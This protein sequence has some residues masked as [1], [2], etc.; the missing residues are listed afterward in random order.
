MTEEPHDTIEIDGTEYE[1]V[2]P[3]FEEKQFPCE[4]RID[5]EVVGFETREQL[6]E[7]VEG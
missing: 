3:M 7:Y 4:V 1:V 6:E 2:R 5:G